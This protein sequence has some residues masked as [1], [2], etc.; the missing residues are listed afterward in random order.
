LEEGSL[1]ERIRKFGDLPGQGNVDLR[2]GMVVALNII[3]LQHDGSIGG[4]LIH[5]DGGN[6]SRNSGA[7]VHGLNIENHGGNIRLA[8][9]VSHDV[10]ERPL[11]IER[12]SATILIESRSVND[13]VVAVQNLVASNNLSSLNAILSLI[14]LA[15]GREGLDDGNELLVAIEVGTSQ[16]DD[17]LNVLND[18]ILA[19]E[20]SDWEIVGVRRDGSLAITR[21]SKVGN[22]C[23]A[24]GHGNIEVGASITR[25][26]LNLVG[27]GTTDNG[28]RGERDNSD[29][30]KYL[31]DTMKK[32]GHHVSRARRQS[33]NSTEAELADEALIGANNLLSCKEDRDDVVINEGLAKTGNG[34]IESS[35]ISI[36]VVVGISADNNHTTTLGAPANGLG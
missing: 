12:N 19:S 8:T 9:T 14:Q 31:L 22:S 32:L 27:N 5:G 1:K 11:G 13:A 15:T 36:S 30:V 21:S 34:R 26:T 3:T 4:V 16:L 7:L 35:I 6:R 17:G 18:G 33:Q 25:D 10:S 29:R 24:W 28:A 23:G 2:S 20:S